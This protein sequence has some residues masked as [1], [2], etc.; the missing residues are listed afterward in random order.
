MSP[1]EVMARGITAVLGTAPVAALASR[2]WADELRI[3]AFHRVPDPAAFDRQLAMLSKRVTFV[4]E[5]QVREAAHGGSPLPPKAVWVT[6]DDGDPTVVSNGLPALA[7]HGVPATI[8]VCPGLI[9]SGSAPWWDIVTGAGEHG[10]GADLGRGHLVGSPLVTALKKIPDE[11]RRQVVDDLRRHAGSAADEGRA[12]TVRAL[13][14]WVDAG[15]TVGNHTWDHPC[16]DQC[17]PAEQA[18]QIERAHRWVEAF[19]PDHRP[20]F[21]YPNGDRTDDAEAVLVALGYDLALLFDHALAAPGDPPLRMSR[22]RLD[23]T[24]SPRRTRAVVSGAHS[25]LFGVRG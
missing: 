13:E 3:L 7:R 9:E 4:S 19:R 1:R 18:D 6:F 20:T 10:H 21:A 2:A 11:Q 14:Q 8:Y 24:S 22:L 5:A 16:L 23:T 25:K 12:I 17:T 15:C